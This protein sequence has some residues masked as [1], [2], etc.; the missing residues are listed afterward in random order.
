MAIHSTAR[1]SLVLHNVHVDWD[2]N[3][4]EIQFARRLERSTGRLHSSTTTIDFFKHQM[5]G[6]CSSTTK[7]VSAQENGAPIVVFYYLYKDMYRLMPFKYLPN[8][9][10]CV[11]GQAKEQRNKDTN[12]NI[13]II[14]IIITIIIRTIIHIIRTFFHIPRHFTEK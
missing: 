1:K 3:E 12:N 4:R 8:G 6:D 2:L 7:Q 11:G 10:A 14:I 5:S 9:N 13:I